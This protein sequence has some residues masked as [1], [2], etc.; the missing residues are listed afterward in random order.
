[1]YA[2]LYFDFFRF[3]WLVIGLRAKVFSDP[4]RKHCV[5]ACASIVAAAK[6]VFTAVYFKKLRPAPA[7]ESAVRISFDRFILGVE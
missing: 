5:F 2:Q 4:T 7:R 1:M 6:H 3:S